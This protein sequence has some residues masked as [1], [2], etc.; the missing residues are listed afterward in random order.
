METRRGM[1]PLVSIKLNTHWQSVGEIY[2]PLSH[3]RDSGSSL[4]SRDARRKSE[5]ERERERER[6]GEGENETTSRRQ[7]WQRCTRRRGRRLTTRRGLPTAPPVERSDWVLEEHFFFSFFVIIVSQDERRC[8]RWIPRKKPWMVNHQTKPYNNSNNN[9]NNNPA[10]RY[11]APLVPVKKKIQSKVAGCLS[12]SWNARRGWDE[13]EELLR[14]FDE[15]KKKRIEIKPSIPLAFVCI[16]YI[17]W[18][19]FPEIGHERSCS[20]LTFGPLIGAFGRHLFFVVFFF[21]PISFK[22][23]P[24]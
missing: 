7:R 5:R 17:G 23:R 1:R 8:H 6:G 24:R 14:W 9:N 19:G 20:L 16:S 11:A 13:A 4:K 12:K 21:E 2:R 3:D 15:E 18:P 22:I 10:G